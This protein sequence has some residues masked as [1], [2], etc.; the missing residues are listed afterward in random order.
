MSNN[1]LKK[2]YS[3]LE[4]S[5]AKLNEIFQ[6]FIVESTQLFNKTGQKKSRLALVAF[7]KL[8]KEYRF[9]SRD[10]TSNKENTQKVMFETY[11]EYESEKKTK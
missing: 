6:T 11:K 2:Q 7:G 5:K 8:A 3:D 1:I 9:L 4:E 10:I